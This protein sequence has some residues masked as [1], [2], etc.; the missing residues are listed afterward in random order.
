MGYGFFNY[1]GD[2]LQV[3]I[4]QRDNPVIEHKGRNSEDPFRHHC[5]RLADIDNLYFNLGI[6]LLNLGGDGAS[7]FTVGAVFGN[8]NS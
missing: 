4:S 2:L 6:G 1:P 7:L 5:L 3:G 8:K